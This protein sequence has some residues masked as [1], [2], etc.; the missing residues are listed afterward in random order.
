MEGFGSSVS[1]GQWGVALGGTLEE[2]MQGLEDQCTL[3]YKSVVKSSLNPKIAA[4]CA[5]WVGV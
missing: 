5:E 1:P 4:I 2:V 3:R